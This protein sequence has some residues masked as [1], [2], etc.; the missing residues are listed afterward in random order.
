[1]PIKIKRKNGKVIRY[2]NAEY[3]PLFYFLPKSLLDKCGELP[4][5]ISRYPYELFTDWKQIELIESDQ[6]ALLMY[7]AF[8]YLVWEYMGLNVGREIYSGDHPAWKFSHAPS[9]WIKTMLDEGVLPPIESLVNDIQPTTFFGFVSDE[10]VD[11]VLKDIVPKTMER[12]GMNEIL[13]VVKEYQCF[14]DFDYRY[15]QQKNDFKNSYY[16]KKTKHPMISLEAFQEDYKK[17][18]DGAEWDKAD[19]RID[20]EGDI[21]AKVDVERFMATLSEKDRQI[22]ELRVEGY[23]YQEIAD[24][25]GYK[26]HS[27]VKKRIDKIGS[28]FQEHTN[29]DIGFE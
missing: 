8:H 13:A 10:Y 23:T 2:K 27:A 19:N 18:H 6:F 21:V 16:H 9:F 15:S 26:T 3:I 12:F 20:L 29:T 22:L 1:M 25:V 4:F 17:N 11:A 7:D 14:E 28:K 5:R 24:K